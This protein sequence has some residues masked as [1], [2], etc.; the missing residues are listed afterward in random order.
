MLVTLSNP[1]AVRKVLS[2]APMLKS[3]KPDNTNKVFMSKSL[4]KEE[5]QKE[6]ECLQKR[7]GL[8]S[9]KGITRREITIRNFEVYVNG[10]KIDQ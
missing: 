6:K 1:W 4:T 9:E 2:K 10:K 7:W 3:F 8:I 5:Q